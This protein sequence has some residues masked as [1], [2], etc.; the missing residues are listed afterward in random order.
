MWTTKGCAFGRE[1]V[2]IRKPGGSPLPSLPAL[3]PLQRLSSAGTGEIHPRR[4]AEIKYRYYCEY[5]IVL[6]YS[7]L[8]AIKAE[9]SRVARFSE[10]FVY[11]KSVCLTL[12]ANSL[13]LW[14]TINQFSLIC[15]ALFTVY[16]LFPN[17]F[18]VAWITTHLVNS[19]AS[20]KYSTALKTSLNQSNLFLLIPYLSW[21]PNIATTG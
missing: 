1:R 21:S 19:L 2:K 16:I 20:V 11:N 10:G 6:F 15:I 5:T 12:S 3:A 13:C 17:S 8:D 14:E 18:A 9:L 4:P 7:A